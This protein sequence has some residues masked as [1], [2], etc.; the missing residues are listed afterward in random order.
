ML[1]EIIFILMIINLVAWVIA[2]IDILRSN[3]RGQNE[4]LI[5]TLVVLFGGFI[6]AILYLFIGTKQKINGR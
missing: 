5:W 1:V 3:F 4:K 6:G 2:L